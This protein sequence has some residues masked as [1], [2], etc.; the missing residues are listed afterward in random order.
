MSSYLT[1]SVFCNP[2][3]IAPFCSAA[4]DVLAFMPCAAS[5]TPPA[6]EPAL[7]SALESPKLKITNK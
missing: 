6:L 1:E 2:L 7:G 3:K 4:V 5:G